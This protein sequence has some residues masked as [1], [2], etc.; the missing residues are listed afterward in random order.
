MIMGI[1]PRRYQE[2]GANGPVGCRIGGHMAPEIAGPTDTEAPWNGTA[3]QQ[4]SRRRG[5]KPQDDDDI[6][7]DRRVTWGSQAA[8]VPEE[9]CW[10]VGMGEYT[11]FGISKS[12]GW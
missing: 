11:P 2:W 4:G 10:W 5:A 8:R 1:R 12:R 3:G 7:L 6:R 9:F